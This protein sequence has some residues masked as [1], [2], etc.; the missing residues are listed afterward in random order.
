MY[1]QWEKRVRE[2]DE[3][4]RELHGERDALLVIKSM[5]DDMLDKNTDKLNDVNE[6]LVVLINEEV[7]VKKWGYTGWIDNKEEDKFRKT[8]LGRALYND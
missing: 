2:L 8:N 3:Q 7:L 4:S 5:V 6:E 1:S